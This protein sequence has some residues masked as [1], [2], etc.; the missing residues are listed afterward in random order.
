MGAQQRSPRSPSP[1][2][3]RAA[4]GRGGGSTLATRRLDPASALPWRRAGV[5]FGVLGWA[6]AFQTMLADAEL[7]DAFVRDFALLNTARPQF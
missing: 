7:T 5:A 4:A 3:H 1:A 2:P 6:I